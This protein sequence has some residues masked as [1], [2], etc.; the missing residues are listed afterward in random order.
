MFYQF[1]CYIVVIFERDVAMMP[2]SGKPHR[3]GSYSRAIRGRDD[4]AKA[5]I[6]AGDPRH[7]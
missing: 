4:V 3:E 2:V 1:L 7:R 6:E 5:H